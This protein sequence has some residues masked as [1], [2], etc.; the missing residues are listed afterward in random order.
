M[1]LVLLLSTL[2]SCGLKPEYIYV[3]RGVQC[4]EYDKESNILKR[5]DDATFG[6]VE[7]INPIS[8]LKIRVR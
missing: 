7:I 3:A 4:K 1:R 2:T 8:V 6:E 5:C